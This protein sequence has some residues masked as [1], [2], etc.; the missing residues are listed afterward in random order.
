MLCCIHFCLLMFRVFWEGDQLVSWDADDGLKSAILGALSSGMTGHSIT[1][2][3]IGGY[4]VVEPS[5]AP[6]SYLRTEELLSRWTEFAAFSAGL[7]RTHI[8]SSRSKLN[9]NVYESKSSMA[10][11]AVFSQIY[12][13]LKSY[14]SMLM[15]EA[16][17]SGTPMIR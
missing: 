14:R 2:T 6:Y 3:D 17:N 7:F 15:E 16:V 5:D 1:H 13:H 8:G 12:A 9:F 11:F 10:H 4:N